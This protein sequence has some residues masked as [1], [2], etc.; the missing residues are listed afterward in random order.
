MNGLIAFW[1]CVRIP[2]IKIFVFINVAFIAVWNLPRAAGAR[3]MLL[4]LLTPYMSWTGLDRQDWNQFA[5]SSMANNYLETE[6]TFR[7][8]TKKRWSFPQKDR[9]GPCQGF[10]KTRY[11][12][13][14]GRFF[15]LPVLWPDAARYVARLHADPNNP[16]VSVT[17][18][19]W[20]EL[21][22]PPT[23]DLYQPLKKRGPIPTH[24]AIFVYE[25]TPS[26]LELK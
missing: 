4:P 15:N 21:I 26:D 20:L 13:W 11:I 23:E 5:F 9:A 25:V 2:V 8:G 14:E 19:H 3:N 10:L 16:P 12:E 22:P 7:D 17:L 6:I 18:L 24:W 1:N